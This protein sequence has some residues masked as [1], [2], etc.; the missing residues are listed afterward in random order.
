MSNVS[1]FP[2]YIARTVSAGA[3]LSIP[4]FATAE[5]VPCDTNC[6][7]ND[8]IQLATNIVNFLLYSLAMPLAA[9]SFA[10]AGF[11]MLTQGGNEATLTKVKSIFWYA[12]LGLIV[13]F[14]AWAIVH[15]VAGVLFEP[16]FQP[17][18]AI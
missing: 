1:K 11:L 6:G 10:Y 8:L 13:A 9:V 14:G 12:L 15:F 5:I 4:L 7:F 2:K 18:G 16:D 3:F 17:T